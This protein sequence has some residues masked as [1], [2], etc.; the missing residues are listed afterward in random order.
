MFSRFP[1]AV[2]GWAIAV[3]LI[4]GMLALIIAGD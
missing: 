2:S 4:V 1:K 3:V